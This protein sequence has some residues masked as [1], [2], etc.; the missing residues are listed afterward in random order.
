MYKERAY[1]SWVKSDGLIS[2]EVKEKETDL[3]ILAETKIEGAARE[4]ILNCRKDIEAYIKKN[5]DFCSSL[6]PISV[7]K[8][9]PDIIKV[10]AAASKKAGIGPMASI[11]GAMAEFVGR[12]LLKLSGEVIIE[13]GGDIFIRTAKSRTVGIYA[14]DRS[15]FTGKLAIEI[16]PSESG[17]GVCTSSG[18]ESHSLSFGK[19]NAVSIISDNTALADAMATATGNIVNSPKEIDKGIEFAKSVDGVKGVLILM[20]NKMASWGKIKLI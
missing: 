16:E 10:M 17:I 5:P 4:A 1:R 6:E 19:A 2:F 11:A 20:D 18:T 13:N 7:K 12:D 8:S 14:G 15:P 3:F 9:A